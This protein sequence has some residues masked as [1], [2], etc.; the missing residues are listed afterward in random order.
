VDTPRM[1]E[2]SRKPVDPA[3]PES[4]RRMPIEHRQEPA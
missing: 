1:P 3:V 4:T 2:S